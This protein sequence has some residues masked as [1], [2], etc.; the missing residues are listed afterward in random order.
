MAVENNKEEYE[1]NIQVLA[2]LETIRINQFI[3]FN[4]HYQKIGSLNG[5]AE[6]LLS[7]RFEPGYIYVITSI[8]GYESA[9]TPQIKIGILDGA[10]YYIF[11]SATVAAAQNAVSYVGQLMC[12]ETDRI[13]ATFEGATAGDEAHLYINGYKIR[14]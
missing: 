6:T 14:R 3:P 8:T 1:K 7:D 4:L 12:K 9:S 2:A 5:T 11:E 13:F 10:T